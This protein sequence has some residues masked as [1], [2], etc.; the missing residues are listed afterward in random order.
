[1]ERRIVE[2]KA[3][4]LPVAHSQPCVLCGAP[5]MTQQFYIF[6]CRCAPSHPARGSLQYACVDNQCPHS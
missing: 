3:R 5:V 1:V 2:L 4:H 6:P